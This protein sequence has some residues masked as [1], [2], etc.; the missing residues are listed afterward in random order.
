VVRVRGARLAGPD[1]GLERFLQLLAVRDSLLVHDHEVDRE[2]LHVPVLVRAEELPDDLAVFREVDPHEH[3]REVSGDAVPPE[4]GLAERVPLENVRRR[5]E[6]RV[7]V[8]NPRRDPLE[9]VRFVGID[10][11]V[12]QLHLRLRPCERRRPLERRRV[13]VLVR[14]LQ[15]LVPQLRDGGRESDAAGRARLEPNPPPQ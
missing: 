7:G 12:A 14:Q 3:D 1:E 6:R 11:Q 8:E 15:R 9:E 10:V 4:G 13:A 5:P 2:S